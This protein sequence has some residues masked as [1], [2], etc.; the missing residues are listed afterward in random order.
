MGQSERD[1]IKNKIHELL[2]ERETYLTFP[3]TDDVN[4]ITDEIASLEKKLLREETWQ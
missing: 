2:R 3:N 4:R 1:Q